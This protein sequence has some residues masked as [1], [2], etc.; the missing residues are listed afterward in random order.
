MGFFGNLFK[1]KICGICGNEIGFLGKRK[2][3]DGNICK[4]CA[5][6]LSPWFDERRS[7]TIAE[8]ARQLEYREK[9]NELI[10]SFHITHTM[11]GD[12]EK[13][14][15]DEKSKK[16]VVTSATDIIKDN[17]DIIDFSFVTGCNMEITDHRT[18]V[19][20]RDKDGKMVSYE[21]KRY[22]CFYDFHITINVNHP[23]F[24]EISFKLNREDVETTDENGAHKNKLP[25]PKFNDIYRKFE[26]IGN[27]IVE[28]MMG[29]DAGAV[30]DPVSDIQGDGR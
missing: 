6:R 7:S 15:V 29:A 12:M 30:R 9:N 3:E 28:Y 4:Q 24:D 23:Y 25:N 11:G 16:F 13:I 8:I 19:M 17:P 14:Y 22:R 5:G 18:E 10:K 1:K 26:D 2:V 20:R 21:P 27:E